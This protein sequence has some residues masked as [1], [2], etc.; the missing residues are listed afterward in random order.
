MN[1]EQ[2]RAYAKRIKNNSVASICP[3]CGNK[4]LFYTTK[5]E[6]PGIETANFEVKCQVCD[7]T[8]LEGEDVKRVAPPG[9]TL[10][11]PLEQ[12]KKIVIYEAERA[13]REEAEKKHEKRN[14]DNAVAGQ[15]QPANVEGTA[16][17]ETV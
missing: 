17:H 13:A 8:V 12:F 2:R 3:K 1:R 4:A 9:I 6:Y 11:I 15:D 14:E 5:V 10:P 16:Q 7:G